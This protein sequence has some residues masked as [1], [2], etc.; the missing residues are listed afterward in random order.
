MMQPP[1]N[2]M[3]YCLTV[4]EKPGEKRKKKKKKKFEKKM[5]KIKREKWMM[6]K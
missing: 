6:K 5:M 1:P 3:S 2:P 4:R